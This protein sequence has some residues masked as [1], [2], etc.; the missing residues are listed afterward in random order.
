MHIPDGFISTQ[1]YLPALA[2][3]GVLWAGAR[4]KIALESEKLPFIAG[5]SAISFTLM[6]IALPLPGGTSVH[7][8]G[9]AIVSLLFG[10]WVSFVAI[11]MVLLIAALLFGEGGITAYSVNV[12]SMAA[13]GSFSAYYIYKAL[14]RWERVALF[15]AG[16]I[17]VVAPAA[18]VALALGIQPLIASDGG[19]PLYFPFGLHVTFGAI[20]GP[21]LLL[22]ILE[23][24][25][26]MMAVR[27]LKGRFSG[28]FGA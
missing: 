24:L 14:R 3:C 6:L 28:V 15:A 19:R 21:H 17:S 4:R 26:T 13:A 1:T 9:V 23:A 22:G 20:V 10:P 27:Y 12:L 25:V 8:S 7:L 18:A 11:S 5:V 2:L 16:W